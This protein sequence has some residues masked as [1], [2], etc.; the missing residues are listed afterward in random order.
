MNRVF[1]V[2]FAYIS[3]HA[4]HEESDHG[5]RRFDQRWQISIHA[6]HEESDSDNKA[7]KQLQPISIHA[8]HEESDPYHLTAGGMV[9]TI[10]IH[11]LHEESDSSN[12]EGSAIMSDFNPRSP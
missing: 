9:D 4:L 2:H 11:A 6:L 8:L 7:S 3:I 1:G 12:A 5:Y 10:S